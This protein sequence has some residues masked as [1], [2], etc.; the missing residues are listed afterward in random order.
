MGI[1]GDYYLPNLELPTDKEQFIG[2][3]GQRRRRYLKHHHKILYYNLLTKGK[4]N[5]HLADTEEQA[6]Q[7]FFR[8]VK[9]LADKENVTEKLKAK[10]QMQWVQKMNNIRNSATEIVNAE[11]I[12]II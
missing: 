1:V 2:V 4:L 7:L 11:L 5:S 10:N 3:W 9:E 6:K 8:L 12:S